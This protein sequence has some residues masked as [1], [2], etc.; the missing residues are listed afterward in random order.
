MRAITALDD[1]GEVPGILIPCSWPYPNFL[2]HRIYDPTDYHN[3]FLRENAKSR[4]KAYEVIH[5]RTAN[6][7]HSRTEREQAHRKIKATMSDRRVR[8]EIK[9]LLPYIPDKILD[10]MSKKGSVLYTKF[11][12]IGSSIQPDFTIVQLLTLAFWRVGPVATVYE[13]GTAI[14]ELFS[15]YNR[16]RRNEKRVPGLVSFYSKD[17][18]DYEDPLVQ[19]IRQHIT[20]VLGFNAGC[21]EPLFTR[22][23]PTH[24]YSMVA[25]YEAEIFTDFGLENTTSL[26][27]R[28][29]PG[30][31]L[32]FNDLPAE[33][34]YIIF[35]KLYEFG[36]LNGGYSWMRRIHHPF[37]RSEPLLFYHGQPGSV[38]E[39]TEV[40]LPDLDRLLLPSLVSHHFRSMVRDTFPK[41]VPFDLDERGGFLPDWLKGVHPMYNDFMGNLII[42][43]DFSDRRKRPR[44]D[45]CYS[46]RLRCKLLRQIGKLSTLRKIE[47]VFDFRRYNIADIQ[48]LKLMFHDQSEIKVLSR[49]KGIRV[50]ISVR[51]TDR[52]TGRCVTS[53][54]RD[55]NGRDILDDQFDWLKSCMK[56][57][58]RRMLPCPALTPKNKAVSTITRWAG[59]KIALAAT[60][61]GGIPA[62]IITKKQRVRW[63]A[64][65]M[66]EDYLN[67]GEA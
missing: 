34:H 35:E 20:R 48:A 24:R 58:K 32:D 11:F 28:H 67:P 26:A 18:F 49:F 37:A 59:G 53:I 12:A 3:Q 19:D 44:I 54:Q 2:S 10:Q 9:G 64:Q 63:L 57:G 36:P 42:P 1:N 41:Q 40:R 52:T 31:P 7:A 66:K 5:L 4:Q 15:W 56:K 47:L 45:G 33:I 8:Q 14:I 55:A 6:K 51:W 60:Q 39:S 62:G 23:H 50:T 30:Q 38:T 43:L 29:Q 25:G 16:V 27:M 22:L 65:Q 61:Y 46:T 17:C 13:L 21:H